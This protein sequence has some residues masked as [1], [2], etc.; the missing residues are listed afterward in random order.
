MNKV[1]LRRSLKITKEL[2]IGLFLM[3][4]GGGGVYVTITD[5]FNNSLNQNL[6]TISSHNGW[7]YHTMFI[8][9]LPFLG[10]GFIISFN[11]IYKYFHKREFKRR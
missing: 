8:W 6:G 11:A 9:M 3:S 2:L 7:G 5:Y 1:K 10:L 4:I